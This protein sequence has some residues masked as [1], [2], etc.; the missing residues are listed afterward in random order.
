[1][2]LTNQERYDFAKIEVGVIERRDAPGTWGVE[3]INQ[4]GDGEIY[5]AIFSGPLAKDRALEYAEMKYGN[6]RF[7]GVTK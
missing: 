3:A 7:Y 6:Y 2:S 4:K 5:M 1:M